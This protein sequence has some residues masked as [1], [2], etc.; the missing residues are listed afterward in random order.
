MRKEPGTQQL[1]SHT[2]VTNVI[3]NDN[4]SNI[5]RCLEV[6]T[7]IEHSGKLTRFNSAGIKCVFV[8]MCV[9]E[10]KRKAEEKEGKRWKRENG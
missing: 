9:T 8:Y 1:I 2:V 4:N 5:C 7:R 3:I 6:R 10:K